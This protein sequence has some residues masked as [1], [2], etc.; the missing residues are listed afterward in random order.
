MLSFEDNLDKLKNIIIIYINGDIINKF[1]E[2]IL[3]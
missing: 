2:K 1:F 3:F